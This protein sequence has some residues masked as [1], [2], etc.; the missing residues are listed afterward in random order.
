MVNPRGSEIFPNGLQRTTEKLSGA[1]G[2]IVR[3]VR[4]GPQIQERSHF[5]RACRLHSHR[6]SGTERHERA[7]ARVGIG[8]K[9][10][11]GLVQILA[12]SL[13]VRERESLVFLNWTAQG[14]PELGSR[15]CHCARWHR[16]QTSNWSGANSGGIPHSSR[17]RKSCLSELARPRNPRTGFSETEEPNPDRNS[18]VRRGH[19]CED[20]QRPSRAIGL[21]R[22][23]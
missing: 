18:S 21:F 16:E 15:S 20:T 19:C 4:N 22:L 14:T 8:N 6:T 3:P 9:R 11:T 23:E 10:Q 1:G 17:T 13:I 5:A 12:V 2:R 7:I